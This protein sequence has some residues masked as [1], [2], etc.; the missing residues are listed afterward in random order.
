MIDTSGVVVTV[1]GRG[2]RLTWSRTAGGYRHV[3]QAEGICCESAQVRV[4]PKVSAK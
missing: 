1:C 3:D 2:H 4:L